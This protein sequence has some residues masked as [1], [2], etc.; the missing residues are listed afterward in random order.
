MNTNEVH[1]LW[2]GRGCFVCSNVLSNV[3]CQDQQMVAEILTENV[4][5]NLCFSQT[6]CTLHNVIIGPAEKSLH[7]HLDLSELR[8]SLSQGK[9]FFLQSFHFLAETNV[10]KHAT[11]L[12]YLD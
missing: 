12:V 5:I 11:I 8:Q 10:L 2:C 6:S 1:T 7:R 9:V 4:Q 3:C